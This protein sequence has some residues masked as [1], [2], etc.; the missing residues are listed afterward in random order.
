[1]LRNTGAKA[2]AKNQMRLAYEDKRDLFCSA[3]CMAL[4]WII[5]DKC[6]CG[7]VLYIFLEKSASKL[8]N[9]KMGGE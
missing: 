1:M 5:N 3:C 4:I 2:F 8:V 7:I 9:T 6:L